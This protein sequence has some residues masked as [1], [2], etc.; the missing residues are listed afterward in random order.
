MR[1]HLVVSCLFLVSMSVLT[2]A[3]GD[4]QT[5]IE[6]TKEREKKTEL[7][8]IFLKGKVVLRG[9]HPVKMSD[10]AW[11][12]ARM[13][14]G[15]LARPI[16]V[17]GI[18]IPAETEINFDSSRQDVVGVSFVVPGEI[19]VCGLTFS[20]RI[21]FR[22]EHVKKEDGVANFG[23][24]FNCA[25]WQIG[26]YLKEDTV[27]AGLPIKAGVLRF[28]VSHIA[29]LKNDVSAISLVEG[30]IAR[31]AAIYGFPLERGDRLSFGPT[32]IVSRLDQTH[33][34][35]VRP[36][37]ER[38]VTVGGYENV[39]TFDLDTRTGNLA[40]LYL[41]QPVEVMGFHTKNVDFYPSGEVHEVTLEG[42]RGWNGMTVGGAMSFWPDG[43]PQQVCVLAYFKG[44]RQAK[45]KLQGIPLL[46]ISTLRFNPKGQLSAVRRG[47]DW[48]RVHHGKLSKIALYDPLGA[49][50]DRYCSSWVAAL[51]K[52]EPLSGDGELGK[53]EVTPSP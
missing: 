32:A 26:G 35:H 40:R 47:N 34:V 46:N 5:T 36:R 12:Q 31:K 41:S 13:R 2:W 27:V 19:D 9:K 22:W 50:A 49:P 29:T 21:G 6:L 37:D 1:T 39:E 11:H 25:D 44:M 28:K 18:T 42:R 16:D 45:K 3:K 20:Q 8:M 38:I 30:T 10:G 53:R 24:P 17:R 51:A 14:T 43:T 48:M 33:W 4:P 23:S 15:T 7:G 52:A